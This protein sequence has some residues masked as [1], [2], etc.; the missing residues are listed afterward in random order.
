MNPEVWVSIVLALVLALEGLGRLLRFCRT[1]RRP[2]VV[3]AT[4]LKTSLK[5]SLKASES[6]P[7]GL[8]EG[9]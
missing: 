6:F 3:L 7:E 5:T 2:V 4:A 8:S 1:R 9:L